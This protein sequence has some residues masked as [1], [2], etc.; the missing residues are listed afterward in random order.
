VLAMF[1]DRET[2]WDLF[3]LFIYLILFQKNKFS[4]Q[5]VICCLLPHRAANDAIAIVFW[6]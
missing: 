1:G 4:G 2:S 5:F 3:Y 6:L